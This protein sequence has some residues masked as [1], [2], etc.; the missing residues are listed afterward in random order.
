LRARH[1]ASE[2]ERTKILSELAP[3][4]LAHSKCPDFIEDGGHYFGRDLSDPT[5]KA[6]IEYLKT[7]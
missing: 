4:L 6:L 2:A 3:D 7:L 1:A 5:K